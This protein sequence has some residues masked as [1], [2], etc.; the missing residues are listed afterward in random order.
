MT[1]RTQRELDSLDWSILRELQADARLSYNALA[2]R[3]GLSSPAVAERVRRLEEAGVIAGYRAEIDPAKIGLPITALIH[4]R[5]D[6]GKCLLKTSSAADFP[7]IVEVLKV[8]GPH[9]TVLKVNVASV[10]HFEAL[11]ERLGAHG[12]LQTSMVWSSP[13]DRRVIDWEGGIPEVEA[14]PDWT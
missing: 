1:S 7:E 9:C 12:Q 2:R 5:C 4:L 13:L 14:P 10:P 11:T 6:H 8:S 3:V